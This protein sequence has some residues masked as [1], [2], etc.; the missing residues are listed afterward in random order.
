M[1][2]GGDNNVAMTFGAGHTC[3]T[4]P[5]R[6]PMRMKSHVSQ[7]ASRYPACFRSATAPAAPPASP[8]PKPTP[9]PSPPAVPVVPVPSPPAVVPVPSPSPPPPR[10][11]GAGTWANPILVDKLPY[12]GAEL[13]VSAHS[14]PALHMPCPLLHA[15]SWAARAVGACSTAGGVPCPPADLPLLPATPARGCAL[16]TYSSGAFAPAP[17]N[18][19]TANRPVTVYR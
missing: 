15:P 14:S 16:Q 4:A 17:C 1:A 9:V 7:M 6:V 2:R 11:A 10:A 3:G 19:L 18:F 12:L 13:S 5:E 8:P